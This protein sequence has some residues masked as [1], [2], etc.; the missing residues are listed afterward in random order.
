MNGLQIAEDFTLPLDAV[1]E[2]FAILAKRGAGKTYT[3]MVMVE[4]MIKAG[5][6]LCV[7]DPLGVWWGLRVSADGQGPGLPIIVLGG[8][9]GDLPMTP[10]MGAQVAQVVVSTR[11]PLVLDL[12]GF[13]RGQPEHFVAD[14]AENIYRLNREP[15]HLFIDE[16][17]IFVPQQPN[18]RNQRSLNAIDDIVRRG[19]VYGLG[20]TL[21]A[22]RAAKVNKD[23]L[24]QTEVLIALRTAGPQDRQV[25]DEWIKQNAEPDQRAAILSSLAELPRGTAWLSSPGWLGEIRRVQI[26]TRETFNSSATPKIGQAV[27][28]PIV[29]ASVD[30]A[31]LRELLEVAGAPVADDAEALRRRIADLERQLAEARVVRALTTEQKQ[32]LAGVASMLLS[33]AAELKAQ[34]ELLIE[35]FPLFGTMTIEPSH[36]QGQGDDGIVFEIPDDALND[37]PDADDG[38]LAQDYGEPLSSGQVRILET[39]ISRYPLRITRAQTARLSKYK[40]TGGA[41]LAAFSG[42]KKADLVVERDGEVWANAQAFAR[43]GHKPQ[44]P[45]TRSEWLAAWRSALSSS[46]WRLLDVLIGAGEKGMTREELG[47]TAGYTAS[48]GA[49]NSYLGVLRNND[50]VVKRGDRY[51]ADPSLLEAP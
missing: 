12:S 25:V 8:D 45:Q 26:R 47:A 34:G 24:T 22:Q 46:E 14:F 19:R 30:V 28:T 35:T 37:E 48:G 33:T 11:T 44:R 17:D 27:Q 49:F 38:P 3:G 6:P 39:L 21:I 40:P 20:V 50:L 15:L 29:A 36:V 32:A 7:I 2:T 9:H 13:S 42:L 16:A 1:T 4:E 5:L 51:Y 23:V 10:E 18:A 31:A 41:F 43:L